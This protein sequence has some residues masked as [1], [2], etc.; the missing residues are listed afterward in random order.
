MSQQSILIIDWEN[1]L[2]NRMM[3]SVNLAI[4]ALGWK[5]LIIKAVSTPKEA[6]HF[7]DGNDVPIVFIG[8]D[9][10]EADAFAMI[11]DVRKRKK[12][13]NF[14]LVTEDKEYIMHAIRL[15]LRLSGCITQKPDPDN[16]KDQLLNLWFPIESL[17][18]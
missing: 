12:Q 17:M 6:E 15:G 10:D 9:T 3:E 8:S 4:S 5:E 7:I 13:V 16:V 1:E 18:A 2:K 11:C 14:I